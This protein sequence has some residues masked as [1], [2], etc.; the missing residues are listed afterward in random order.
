MHLKSQHLH[1]SLLNSTYI[2]SSDFRQCR[3]I[4]KCCPTVMTTTI[5]G[6]LKAGCIKHSTVY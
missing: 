4:V 1:A 6:L 5:N 2:T 3:P